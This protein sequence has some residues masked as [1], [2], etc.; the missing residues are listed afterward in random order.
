[1]MFYNLKMSVKF[2]SL[3]LEEPEGTTTRKLK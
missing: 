3:E 2:Q 1:M